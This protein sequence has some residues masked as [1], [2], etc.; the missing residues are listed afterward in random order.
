M[1]FS[2]PTYYVGYNFE[3]LQLARGL[4][5]ISVI[6]NKQ[7]FVKG[8]ATPDY[9]IDNLTQLLVIKKRAYDRIILQEIQVSNSPLIKKIN[10]KEKI[11]LQ[12]H[13]RRIQQH[14]IVT[15]KFMYFQAKHLGENPT[16]WE[17]TGILHDIDYART[18]FNIEDHGFKSVPILKK[19]NLDK[20]LIRAI[21]YHT[22][23]KYCYTKFLLGWSLY[24]SEMFTKRFV[25]ALRKNDYKDPS[26]VRFSD[27]MD[28]YKGEDF[29]KNERLTRFEP[30]SMPYDKF[31]F[32][33]LEHDKTIEHFPLSRKVLFSL[34]QKAFI[35]S[36]IFPLSITHQKETTNLKLL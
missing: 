26:R 18:Y 34:T 6:M 1:I 7:S 9:F 4:N 17:E 25:H 31:K 19:Y 10:S 35:E 3:D 12:N 30:P 24:I 5:L 33:M 28:V 36:H 21:Q 8:N 13:F 23:A 16:L 11:L 15:G 2:R 20:D 29:R 14:S 27:F 22:T 32:M